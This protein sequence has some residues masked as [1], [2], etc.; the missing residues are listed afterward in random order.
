MQGGLQQERG[1]GEGER[2]ARAGVAGCAQTVGCDSV[3]RIPAPADTIRTIEGYADCIVLRHFAAGCVSASAH[4]G[5]STGALHAMD[6]SGRA[7][8]R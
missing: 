2:A 4:L 8:A 6:L 7:V 5:H 1:V 3:W